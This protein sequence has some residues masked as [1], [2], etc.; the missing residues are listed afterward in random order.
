MVSGDRRGQDRRKKNTKVTVDR[1]QQPRRKNDR[2]SV[3]RIPLELWMEEVSGDDIYFRRSGNIGEGGV[4]FDMAAPHSI[5][6]MMTLKFALPGEH[7]MIIARGEVVSTSGT[8]GS[9]GMRVKFVNIEGDGR[10]RLREYISR[11]M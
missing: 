2:R 5:G 4:Y 9:G 10:R 3:K 7:E 11:I 1:R 8:H 6:T